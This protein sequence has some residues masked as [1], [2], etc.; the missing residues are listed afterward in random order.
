MSPYQSSEQSSAECSDRND[1]GAGADPIGPAG[2]TSHPEMGECR[3]AFR[4]NILRNA[5]W[6][7]SLAIG[8][9]VCGVLLGYMIHQ[10]GLWPQDLGL[11]IGQLVMAAVVVICSVLLVRAIRNANCDLLLFQKG[12]VARRGKQLE[13]IQWDDIDAVFEEVTIITYNHGAATQ[14]RHKLR[15]RLRDQRETRL[16]LSSFPESEQIS[17]AI[18]NATVPRMLH[19]AQIKL[20]AGQLVEFGFVNISGAGLERPGDVSGT[21]A[22]GWRDVAE[23]TI[24][25]GL[26]TIKSL[27]GWKPWASKAV[28]E[29]PN[30]RV[31]IELLERYTTDALMPA[32]EKPRP[33]AELVA[34]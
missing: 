25:D 19:E 18:A 24:D 5:S 11:A 30:L 13:K 10:D 14:I 12:L 29:I 23:F 7:M 2:G 16:D 1:P 9:A 27:K 34:H 17:A 26:L 33:Q 3:A 6:F 28:E 4:A 31:L 15:F 20:G 8:I 21:A 32:D 22:L